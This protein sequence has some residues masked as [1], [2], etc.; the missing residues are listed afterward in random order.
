M[1][2]MNFVFKKVLGVND[3]IEFA[4]NSISSLFFSNNQDYLSTFRIRY[5]SLFNQ[6]MNKINSYGIDYYHIT[7]GLFTNNRLPNLTSLVIADLK[8]NAAP[9]NVSINQTLNDFGQEVCNYLINKKIPQQY[10]IGDN[11]NIT[12]SFVTS[13]INTFNQGR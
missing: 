10:V 11:S 3:N 5:S 7:L 8:I 1:G 4:S 13:Y 12:Y 6:L 2:I 9:K